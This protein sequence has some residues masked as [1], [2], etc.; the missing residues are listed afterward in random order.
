LKLKRIAFGP[1]HLGALPRGE[2]RFLTRE[3]LAALKSTVQL[4]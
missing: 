4:R 1:L 2:F 3:E